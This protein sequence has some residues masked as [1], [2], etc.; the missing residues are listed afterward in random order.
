MF[1]CP[2]ICYFVLLYFA[3]LSSMLCDLFVYVLCTVAC[4]CW[5]SLICAH[6]RGFSV[7]SVSLT[8]SLTILCELVAFAHLHPTVRGHYTYWTQRTGARQVNKGLRL[9]YFVLSKQ[10]AEGVEPRDGTEPS[11]DQGKPQPGGPKLHDCYVLNETT[12]GVSDHA[13]IVL[14]LAL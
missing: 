3:K 1:E 10:M 12:Q 7:P 9:D 5:K 11:V 13:P 14:Q 8:I 4:I 2:F 6:L